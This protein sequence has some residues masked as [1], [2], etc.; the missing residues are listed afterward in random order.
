MSRRS[1]W[2]LLL[3]VTACHAKLGNGPADGQN[4]DAPI[5]ID[6][7]GEAGPDAPLGPWGAPNKIMSAASPTLQEDDCTMSS[8]QLE[9]YFAIVDATTMTKD[10]YVAKRNSKSADF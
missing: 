8:N 7:P 3:V 9:L 5:D 4:A 2:G 6:G 1:A 10:L